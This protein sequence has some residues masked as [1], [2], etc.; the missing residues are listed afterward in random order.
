MKNGIEIFIFLREAKQY[1]IFLRGGDIIIFKYSLYIIFK[2]KNS[3][4]ENSK[5]PK[6]VY[7]IRF[8]YEE[9]YEHVKLKFRDDL[10]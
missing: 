6:F 7:L 8:L 2:N 4:L 5:Y 3:N 1:I 9:F 10:I